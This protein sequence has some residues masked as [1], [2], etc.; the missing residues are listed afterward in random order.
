MGGWRLLGEGLR[1]TGKAYLCG[2]GGGVGEVLPENFP[3]QILPPGSHPPF[4]FGDLNT[5]LD[6]IL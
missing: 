6:T 3:F 5:L 2:G 4:F 1:E